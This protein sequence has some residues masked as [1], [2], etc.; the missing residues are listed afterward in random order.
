MLECF[1]KVDAYE[2]PKATAHDLEKRF[3]FYS[4]QVFFV[5]LPVAGALD[6]RVIGRSVDFPV[7][8]KA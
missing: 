3:F 8:E 5:L 2:W 7:M 4:L 6:C 1:F